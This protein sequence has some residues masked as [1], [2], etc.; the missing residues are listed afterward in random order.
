MV[1]G[2]KLGIA[3]AQLMVVTVLQFTENLTDRQACEAVQDRIAWK[4]ALGL[5]LDEPGFDPTVLSE[6]RDRLV[7]EDLVRLAL[8]A[9]LERLVGQGLVKAG[10]GCG[11]IPPTWWARPGT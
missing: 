4:Y 11:P 10:A 6:F 2:R 8:D 5:E 9:L 3:P 7:R 1:I